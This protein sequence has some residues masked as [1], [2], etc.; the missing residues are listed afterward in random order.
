MTI[1]NIDIEFRHFHLFCGLGGG[2]KGFNKGTAR[3]GSLK[4]RF[5]CIG[6]IDVDPASIRDFSR[7]AGVEGTVMDLFDADQY[8]AFH[9]KAPPAGWRPAMPADIRRAA[10]GERPHIVF[11]SAPCKGF[12]GLLPEKSSAT[13]KYQ[14]LN[15]LTLRGVWLMLEAWK[16]DPE[17]LPELII[18]EN[19]PRIMTRGRFLIDQI[20]ALLRAYGFAVAETTHDCGEIGGLGQSRKRYLLVARH[21]EK[22]PPF[23]YEPEKRR[24]RGVGEI[25][26]RLPLPGDLRAGPMHRMPALQWKTWV[27]LAFVEAGSDWRSL[28]KLAVENGALRDFGIMPESDWQSGVLGV[29]QWQDTSGVVAGRSSPT[30]GAF[31]VADP[32]P[33]NFPADRGGL[34]GVGKWG[35]TASLIT[36][37][38]SPQ[39][40]RYSVADP[41]VDGHPKSVQLGVRKWEQTAAVVKGDVSVGT[42][43]YA[44]A[45]PSIP[46]KPRFNNVFRIVPWV[47]S[48]PAVAGPGGPAG[49]LAVADPRPPQ[50]EDYKVTKYRV[51]GMNEAAGAVI[52]ASTIGNGA[53]AVAD[54]MLNWGEGAHASKL[55]VQGWRQAARPVTGAHMLSGLGTVADPRPAEDLRSGAH[56]VRKWDET[57][58]TVQGESL[59]SNGS[60]A[61]A[62]PRP[63][64]SENTHQN[65]L[66]VGKWGNH[67]KAATGATH[68][69]GGALSVADPRPAAFGDKRENYQTGGHYGVVS[70]NGTAYAVP[71]FAKHDR[72]N[73]SVADPRETEVEPLFDLPKPDDRLVAVIRALDG[74][75]HRPFTTLELA[76]LQSLVDPDEIVEGFSLDGQSDSAWRERIGNAV[77]P[78]AAEAIAGV[79]GTTLL[80][81]MTGETFMLSSQ[82]IWVREIATALATDQRGNIPWEAAE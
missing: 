31:S 56:G 28:N 47:G 64:Y 73:W 70:W 51:T 20:I 54:P 76:A 67:S 36:S 22:V 30:N 79:M 32:R 57:S 60:F 49:G 6:G 8:R 78:D 77:P 72:G 33:E 46:G 53:F 2:A 59:P 82:P 52:A 5:R 75:W 14:A 45:D 69:A 40:G 66:S 21:E 12:S 74:T 65:I 29:R 62:D 38:R 34:L 58:G 39:Q 50:R 27:R 42:G 17:G 41:R 55:A 15:G 3:V 43:P 68:V 18:F 25:L 4:A 19:V 63:G 13:D 81:A 80:L 61:V 1:S 44:V 48:A 9:G 7:A 16:D 24:L 11:L 26:E 71:G 37:Q 10:H 35:E 23:L